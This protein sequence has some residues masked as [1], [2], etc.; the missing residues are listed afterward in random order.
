MRKTHTAEEHERDDWPALRSILGAHGRDLNILEEL[1]LFINPPPP[2]SSFAI[3]AENLAA[4]LKR[5]HTLLISG[6]RP[7]SDLPGKVFQ[8]LVLC[9]FINT[10][11]NEIES[12]IPGFCKIGKEPFT[13]PLRGYYRT[14]PLSVALWCRV[15]DAALRERYLLLQSFLCASHYYASLFSDT[16]QKL[17][18][19]AKEGACLA[20]RKLANPE[21]SSKLLEFPAAVVSFHSYRDLIDPIVKDPKSEFHNLGHFYDLAIERKAA[22]ARTRYGKSLKIDD[23]DNYPYIEELPEIDFSEESEGKPGDKIKIFTVTGVDRRTLQEQERNLC[24]PLEFNSRRSMVVLEKPGP[25][26]SGGLSRGQQFLQAKVVSSVI[27]MKNQRLVTDW[28]RLNA[29]EIETFL[30][31]ILQ[32]SSQEGNIARVPCCELAA[33][34]TIVFWISASPESVKECDLLPAAARHG[35][36]LGILWGDALSRY[37]VVKPRVPLQ[38]VVSPATLERQALPL[39][40]RYTLPIP[41]PATQVMERHLSRFKPDYNT[42]KVFK[43]DINEYLL[44]AGEFFGNLR[45]TVGGRQNLQR[46]SMHLHYM[47]ARMAGC[48]ITV[49]MSITGRHDLLGTVPNHY[50][51]SSVK[52]LSRFYR[53]ACSEIIANSSTTVDKVFNA[54][55]D[56]TG[57]RYVGSSYVP[58]EDTVIALVR[59]MRTRLKTARDNLRKGDDSPLRLHNAITVYTVMMIGFATGYRAK[60]DPLLQKAEIDRT[61]GFGVISD[62]DGDDLYH[63]RIIWLPELC[64]LQLELYQEHLSQFENWLFTHNQDLFFAS[65]QK[66]VTGRRLERE[67]PS[68]FFIQNDLSGLEVRPKW[69]KKLMTVMDY[70]LPVNANRHF[71]RTSLLARRCPVEVINAFMGH[72]ESGVEPWGMYSGLSPLVYR[73]ELTDYLMYLLEDCGWDLESGLTG[74]TWWF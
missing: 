17:V 23:N 53:Q 66:D 56:A 63:S 20:A 30:S 22:H 3:I 1:R 71:L 19:S 50:T 72:W 55:A 7:T 37:W 36:G 40:K 15:S 2:L 33:F 31:G 68:L 67:T 32:L 18:E 13:P 11:R 69:I 46:V 45:R 48:D 73:K 6:T 25:D 12:S 49:A 44:A 64:F 9:E 16:K 57:K 24:S 21:F 39:A 8:W 65:R 35:E 42:V 58:R 62:K 26:P 14:N 59:D 54:T 28:E 61:T 38:T 34:L 74:D 5:L 60:R 27:K 70:D 10:I 29:H 52:A 4:I 43:R 51:A 41:E 47:I